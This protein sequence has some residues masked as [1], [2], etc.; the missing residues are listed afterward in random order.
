MVLTE[1]SSYLS[2]IIL[3]VMINILLLLFVKVWLVVRNLN[4]EKLHEFK[5]HYS[6]LTESLKE[7]TRQ[8]LV[9]LWKPLYLLR[10]SLTLSILIVL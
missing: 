2:V 10:W 4:R 1:I 9:Y 3:V 7:T 5:I 8:K 6:V